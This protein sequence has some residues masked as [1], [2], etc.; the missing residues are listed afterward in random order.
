MTR[1]LIKVECRMC[2]ILMCDWEIDGKTMSS[3]LPAYVQ[4]LCRACAEQEM[5]EPKNQRPG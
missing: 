1:R 4:N 2:G 5:K 3:L